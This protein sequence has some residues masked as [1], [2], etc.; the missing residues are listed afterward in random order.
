MKTGL[1]KRRRKK[2][3]REQLKPVVWT[4]IAMAGTDGK[5]VTVSVCR[6][7]AYS[8]S[9]SLYPPSSGTRSKIAAS[10]PQ[11]R[12]RSSP[13]QGSSPDTAHGAYVLTVKPPYRATGTS[14][15]RSGFVR[16]CWRTRVWKRAHARSAT[17][18]GYKPI[19]Q[20]QSIR[21]EKRRCM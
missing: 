3:D 1:P 7:Q 14:R 13:R 16:W 20:E 9:C 2:A 21:R 8:P 12:S 11:H 15:Y 4:Q 5:L 10:H 17:R 18:S 6:N 19:G